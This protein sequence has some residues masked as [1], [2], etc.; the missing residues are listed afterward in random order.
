MCTSMTLP[1]GGHSPKVSDQA[2][3][4]FIREATMPISQHDATNTIHHCKIVRCLRV[5][6]INSKILYTQ[7]MVHTACVFS[8]L[9]LEDVSLPSFRTQALL[10]PLWETTYTNFMQKINFHTHCTLI[11]PVIKQKRCKSRQII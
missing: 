9:W 8:F 6:S 7:I 10:S 1:R 4:G 3:R 11:R 5:M 2:K